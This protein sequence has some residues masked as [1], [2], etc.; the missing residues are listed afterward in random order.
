MRRGHSVYE[1]RQ[2][3]ERRCDD[4]ALVRRVLDRLKQEKLLDDAR[5]SLEFARS[6]ARN[7]K[8]GRFR[9]VRELR[10]RGVPERHIEVALNEAFGET[11][12]RELLRKRIER[13]L[14][15]LRGPLDEKKRA[16]MYHSLLRA[17]FQADEIRAE[18]K[19]F[20]SASSEAPGELPAID[21]AID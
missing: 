8:Q 1:M 12:E 11:D 17:G 14:R 3:L 9:I 10:A 13:K 2:A 4:G 5:Y 16:S 19:S 6:R 21:D 18:L 7:R 20:A 15:L